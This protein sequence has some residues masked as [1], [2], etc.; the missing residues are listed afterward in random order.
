MTRS[1]N[2][3]V[4]VAGTRRMGDAVVIKYSQR[5]ENNAPGLAVKKGPP[6]GSPC[7]FLFAGKEQ[8]S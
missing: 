3:V 5:I 7:V 2:V 8:L 4:L 1:F 6:Y